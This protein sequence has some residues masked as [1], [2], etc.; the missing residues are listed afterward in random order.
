MIYLYSSKNYW[1]QVILHNHLNRAMDVE[2]PLMLIYS[3]YARDLNYSISHCI[4]LNPQ[5][6]QDKCEAIL[7]IQVNLIEHRLEKRDV[8]YC[9]NSD[10]M[11]EGQLASRDG[12]LQYC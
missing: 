1:Q 9:Q 7:P 10:C 12:N 5:V 8:K 2:R 3:S 4:W 11:F 6:T